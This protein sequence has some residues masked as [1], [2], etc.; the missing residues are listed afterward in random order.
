M[1]INCRVFDF[2]PGLYWFFPLCV[3][4][5]GECEREKLGARE[6]VILCFIK[7]SIRYLIAA[8]WFSP[9]SGWAR[10]GRSPQVVGTVLPCLRRP[11]RVL[12]CV[13]RGGELRSICPLK[14][15]FVCLLLSYFSAMSDSASLHVMIWKDKRPAIMRWLE[16]CVLSF[17]YLSVGGCLQFLHLCVCRLLSSSCVLI[18]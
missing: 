12:L 14:H 16:I 9:V 11:S 2:F 3:F 6:N 17:P 10:K 13:W 15:I 4:V 1:L 8:T 18:L 5:L 7:K